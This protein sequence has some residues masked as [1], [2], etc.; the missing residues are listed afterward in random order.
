LPEKVLQHL[1]G[2][3][4]SSASSSDF[5]QQQQQQQVS[6]N[7][8]QS[9][10]P[11]TVTSSSSYCGT[12]AWVPGVLAQDVKLAIV[13]EMCHLGSVFHMIAKARKVREEQEA[14]VSAVELRRTFPWGLQFY[15][16]WLTRLEVLRGAAAGVEY[17][18]QHGVVHRDLTS[19]NLLLAY[20][21]P[22]QVNE[23]CGLF[24]L[25]GLVPAVLY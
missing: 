11:S 3:Q 17:M 7:D 12:R 5:Q 25:C 22:W 24:E 10:L 16:D 13:M 18:H 19:Y 2:S 15:Q 6:S 20:G 1:L 4:S 21:R 14:G 9:S 8:R 23:L